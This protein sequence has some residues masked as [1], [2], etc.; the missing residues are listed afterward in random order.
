MIKVKTALAVQTGE[1]FFFR[2][3]EVKADEIYLENV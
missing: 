3:L 1:R 2:V